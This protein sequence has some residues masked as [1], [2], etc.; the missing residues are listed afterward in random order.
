MVICRDDLNSAESVEDL[1]VPEDNFP[2]E[3]SG[4]T[5]NSWDIKSDISSNRDSFENKK[6]TYSDNRITLPFLTKYEKARIL[7][8]RALQISLGAPVMVD[9]TSET[10]ALDIAS[11]ELKHRKI[12]ITIRRYLPSGK[13]EDWN[14]DELIIE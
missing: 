14:L 3:T 11:K 1:N 13:F 7:G 10:D 6:N 9:L 8:A 5:Q 12:P 2:I 4:P